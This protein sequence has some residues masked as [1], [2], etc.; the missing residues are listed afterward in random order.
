MRPGLTESQARL[1]YD[2]VVVYKSSFRA[3][4]Q[5]LAGGNEQ[6]FAKLLVDH[7]SDRVVGVHMVGAD[8]AEIIQGMAIA[9]RAG[10]TKR[11][12]DTTLGVHPTSAEEFVTL[13]KP[14]HE[15]FITTG[16]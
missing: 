14:S 16:P 7:A 10:A 5:T 12:F 1:R 13:R 2:D 15:P 4:K 3:L 11:V 8:A 9:L 6:T